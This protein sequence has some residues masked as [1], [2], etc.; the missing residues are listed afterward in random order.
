MLGPDE[1]AAHLEGRPQSIEK[2]RSIFEQGARVEPASPAPLRNLVRPSDSIGADHFG[3]RIVPQEKMIIV[4][5]K[6]VEIERPAASFACG[7]K[8]DLPQPS[9]LAKQMRYLCGRCVE[10][11][12]LAASDQ[13]LMRRQ[14]P[15]II[16]EEL[17]FTGGCDR[18]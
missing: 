16:G 12:K 3:F 2:V 14:L 10:D 17:S 18:F 4:Q 9:D 7:P 1:S 15:E 5:V 6:L 11:P 13:Q 8:S